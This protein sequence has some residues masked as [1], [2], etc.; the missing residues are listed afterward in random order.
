MSFRLSSRVEHFWVFVGCLTVLLAVQARFG[1]WS[2]EFGFHPDESAHYVTGV[3][4]KEFIEGG[5]DRHPMRFA[6]QYYVRYPRLALGHWPPLFPAML[7]GWM[8]LFGV[9]RFA[10]YFLLAL[11]GAGTATALYALVRTEVSAWWAAGATVWWLLFERQ[12]K[13]WASSVMTEIPLTLFCL[14][15]LAAYIRYLQ[16]ERAHWSMLFGLAAGAALLT[17]GLGVTLAVVPP[18]AVLAA[19]RLE[20]LL[21]WSFWAPAAVT[22]CIAGPW[23]GLQGSWIPTAFGGAWQRLTIARMGGWE[24]RLAALTESLGPAVLLAVAAAAVAAAALRTRRRCSPPVAVLGAYVAGGLALHFALPESSEPRHLFHIAPAVMALAALALQAVVARR[25]L[26]A[27]PAWAPAAG[28]ALLAALIVGRLIWPAGEGVKPNRGLAEL[29]EQIAA[30]PSLDGAVI[31]SASN[32][33]AEGAFVA[34]MARLAPDPRW[35]VLR[36]SK[37]LAWVNWAAQ[38]QYVELYESASAMT[39]RLA[40]LQVAVVV[41]AEGRYPILPHDRLLLESM[42]AQPDRWKLLADRS[43]Q[44]GLFRLRAFRSLRTDLLPRNP[45]RIDMSQ[46]LGRIVEASPQPSLRGVQP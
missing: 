10:V 24:D 41:V 25:P 38:G 37:T 20:L 23:Y 31:L 2:S 13:L 16:T 6:E 44:D 32:G 35:F 39:E 42:Q 30:D 28:A 33:N 46:R 12:T 21:R 3:M 15:A 1:A 19:G 4:V 27:R 8:T 34:E 17:K 9:G 18:L 40:A 11:L 5:W 45:I 7:G 43:Y 22:I 29:A 26:R 14:L 36:S